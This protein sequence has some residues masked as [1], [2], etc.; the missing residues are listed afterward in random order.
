MK[1]TLDYQE[2]NRELWNTKTAVHLT[3][4]FYDLPGF[5]AGKNSLKPIELS[6]LGDVR[7]KDILHLQCH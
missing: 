2:I 5:L 1:P 7:E 4:E 3:S 6:M